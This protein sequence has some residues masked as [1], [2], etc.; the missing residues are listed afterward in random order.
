MGTCVRMFGK[1]LRKEEEQ[2][3]H[4]KGMRMS[5]KNILEELKE[6]S[7]QGH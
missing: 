4:S 5:W 2:S 7:L 3:K 1:D 6:G